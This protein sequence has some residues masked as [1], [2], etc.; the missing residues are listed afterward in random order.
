MAPV[1]ADPRQGGAFDT[2]LRAGSLW[3]S[4]GGNTRDKRATPRRATNP[5]T[6]GHRPKKRLSRQVSHRVR[7]VRWLLATSLLVHVPGALRECR[8]RGLHAQTGTPRGRPS[9]G[10][11]GFH[12]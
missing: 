12:P 5:Q 3:W 9:Q 11:E 8:D 6:G 4:S 10:T 7:G 2:T 1:A